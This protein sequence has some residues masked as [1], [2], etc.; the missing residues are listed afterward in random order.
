MKDD[1]GEVE[2]VKE[3]ETCNNVPQPDANQGRCGSGLVAETGL[4]FA[5]VEKSKYSTPT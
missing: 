1:S 2:W 4:A 5:Q 3:M